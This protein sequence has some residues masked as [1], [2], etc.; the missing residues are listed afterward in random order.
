MIYQKEEEKVFKKIQI[1]NFLKKVKK[2][3]KFSLKSNI[4]RYNDEIPND[5]QVDNKDSKIN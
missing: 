3:Q 1:G 5:E 4:K 2:N